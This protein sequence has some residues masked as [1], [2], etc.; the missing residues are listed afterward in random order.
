MIKEALQYIVGM[1][2]NEM[3]EHEG[4]NYS[5]K[6]LHRLDKTPGVAPLELRSLSGLVDYIK[7]NFD[8]DLKLMV[9]VESPTSV[10]VFDSLDHDNNRRIYV[11][12]NA[13][14]PHITFERFQDTESFNIM[15]QSCF[16][17]NDNRDKL[18]KI[19]GSIVED[20]AVTTSDDGVSQRVAART[21]VAA[22]DLI[23]AP[24]PIKLKPF[25]T[26]VEVTQP[27]SEFIL[28]LR[29]GPEAALFEADGAAWELNAMENIKDHLA[30]EL[31]ELIEQKNVIIVA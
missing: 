24:N 18:L 5:T 7:S 20:E 10:S 31:K 25:R 19:V 13:M 8:H 30:K 16:V 12:A 1:G 21:G 22:I 4:K 2:K 14:L 6:A 17:K 26:F 27:E 23:E 29:K 15:L 28:R 11:Q 3:V 9:H